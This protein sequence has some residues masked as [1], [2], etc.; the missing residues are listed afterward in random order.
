VNTAIVKKRWAEVTDDLFDT[1]CLKLDQYGA[2]RYEQHSNQFN[3]WM[4][5]SDIHRK[6]LRLEELT[7]QSL[8]DDPDGA[9]RAKLIDDYK[10]IANYAIMAVQ[11]LE[12]NEDE[13]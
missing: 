4:C 13:V 5:F 12:E 1:F 2:S 10:D 6:T 7:Q 3:F 11:I 9:S 8:G